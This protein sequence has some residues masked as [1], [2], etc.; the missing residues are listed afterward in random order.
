[1]GTR[2]TFAGLLLTTALMGCATQ[3]Q[4]PRHAHESGGGTGD[5]AYVIPLR[6]MLI[7]STD[8]DIVEYGEP[9]ARPPEPKPEPA[10]AAKPE[11]RPEG[12]EVPRGDSEPT[13]RDDMD[14]VEYGEPEE[15]PP[16]VEI[17][18]AKDPVKDDGLAIIEYGRPD[19][20]IEIKPETKDPDELYKFLSDNSKKPAMAG[21]FNK[22]ARETS[23]SVEWGVRRAKRW[24]DALNPGF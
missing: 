12:V 10:P 7:Q 1:M 8:D 15:R 16:G 21:T 5:A 20:V 14:V 24:L 4:A 22:T 19:A 11:E 3:A 9:E 23:E 2:I 17:E 18:P 13:P 6:P